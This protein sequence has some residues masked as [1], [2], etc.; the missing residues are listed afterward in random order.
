MSIVVYAVKGL[1]LLVNPRVKVSQK[2]N[3]FSKIYYEHVWET[4]CLSVKLA[5]IVHI[6]FPTVANS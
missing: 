4:Y 1:K 5:K 2:I 3:A 6:A